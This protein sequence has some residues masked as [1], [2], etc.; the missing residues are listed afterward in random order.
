MIPFIGVLCWEE[1]S[2]TGRLIG[3]NWNPKTFAFPIKVKRLKGLNYETVVKSPNEKTLRLLIKGAQEF[4]R[5][6]AGAISTDCGFNALWQ[7]ELSEAV[8][9]PVLTSGLLLVP[10][11]QTMIGKNKKVAIL[12]ADSRHLTYRHLM[13]AGISEELVKNCI[14]V[15][16]ENEP[17][18]FNAATSSGKNIKYLDD[19]AVKKIRNTLF[20][21]SKRLVEENPNVR[22][23]VLECTDLPPF[24]ETIQSTTGIPVFDVVGLM[25]MVYQAI[26][27]KSRL[28]KIGGH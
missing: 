18:F 8:N 6:G 11:I 14:I 27:I 4:D 20:D 24:A 19:L 3:V 22:A 13:A 17:N 26:Y 28:Q 23:I 9:V 2:A 12:T 15:G 21:I 16:L 25:K 1:D 5:E 10:L 7:K